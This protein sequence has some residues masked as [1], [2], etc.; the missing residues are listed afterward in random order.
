MILVTLKNNTA[1]VNFLVQIDRL[2]VNLK[3]NRKKEAF[4]CKELLKEATFKSL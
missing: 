4:C 1:S 3:N 2:V